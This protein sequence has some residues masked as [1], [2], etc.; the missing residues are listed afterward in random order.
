MTTTAAA[1]GVPVK[2][3]DAVTT[4]T[5]LGVAVPISSH[6]PRIH[7]YAVGIIASGTVVLEEARDPDY[8]GTWSTL[9]TYTPA[10]DSEQVVHVFGTLGVVRAR[11]TANIVGGGTV[12]VELVS[13]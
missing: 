8:T 10:T 11:V 13:D 1:K 4:G 3:L 5:G 7:F 9:F 6:N 2:L 12:T